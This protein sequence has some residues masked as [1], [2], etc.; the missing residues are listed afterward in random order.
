MP[1][2]QFSKGTK[3]MLQ[4]HLI[5]FIFC[6]IQFY[7]LLLHPCCLSPCCS[8]LYELCSRHLFAFGFLIDVRQLALFT[9]VL[10]LT[11]NAEGMRG[12]LHT[13]HDISS[14]Q[15]HIRATVLHCDI[16]CKIP[17]VVI[18]IFFYWYRFGVNGCE[19]HLSVC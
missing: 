16:V 19:S 10:C 3:E 12:V 9:H 15:V 4:M 18:A 7:F 13:S 5:T 2:S 6:E 17:M 1:A 8:C 14:F 11:G